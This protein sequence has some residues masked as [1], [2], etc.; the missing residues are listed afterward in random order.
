MRALALDLGSK[1]IGLALSDEAGSIATPWE[2]LHR[3]GTVADCGALCDRVCARNIEVIVIGLPLELDGRIGHRAR[4]VQRF[5]VKLREA[6]AACERG[7]VLVHEWDERFST[8]A[9]HRSMQEG[10][11]S[12]RKQKERV[13]AVAAQ[14]ILSG[15][16]DAQAG[17]VASSVPLGESS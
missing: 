17:R 6:L 5:A 1:T 9:A 13:D 3:A 10:D 4:L 7:D 11:L 12:R 15:W 8:A 2:V 14:F 16:L